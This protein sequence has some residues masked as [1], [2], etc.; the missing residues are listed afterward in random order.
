[1]EQ[2]EPTA[3][4]RT[5]NCNVL[6]PPALIQERGRA[7]RAGETDERHRNIKKSQEIEMKGAY[8]L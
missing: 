8:R 6:G 5:P 2:R 7:G 3:L 4:L 1:M